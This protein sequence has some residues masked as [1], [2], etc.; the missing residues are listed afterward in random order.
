MNERDDNKERK[1]REK[2]GERRSKLGFCVF[3]DPTNLS[4]YL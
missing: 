1:R 2:N 3:K 4:I